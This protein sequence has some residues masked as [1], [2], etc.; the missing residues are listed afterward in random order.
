MIIALIA[1][2]AQLHAPQRATREAVARDAPAIVTR[3]LL[4]TS[5]LVNFR[6]L[7]QPETVYY[8]R[9]WRRNEF[10]REHFR[11]AQW[12]H[13]HGSDRG[14]VDSDGDG[15]PDRYDREPNNPYRN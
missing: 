12:R 8:G 2:V 10:R 15:V 6:V 14:W 1:I 5:A 7:V 4:D 3:A 9:D 13:Q 11:R